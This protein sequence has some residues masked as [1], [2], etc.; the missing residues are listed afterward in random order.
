VV[1]AVVVTR[2]PLARVEVMESAQEQ[3]D[4]GQGRRG[5]PRQCRLHAR[6]RIAR[7]TIRA[8]VSAA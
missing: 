1:T 5:A 3:Q 6:L 2:E 4:L 8:R 7:S